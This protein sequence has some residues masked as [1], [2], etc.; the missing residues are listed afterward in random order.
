M[1]L[2]NMSNQLNV[3]E[4]KLQKAG[5]F[6]SYRSKGELKLQNC[7]LHRDKTPSLSINTIDKTYN[8][9]SCGDKGTINKLLSYFGID[10]YNAPKLDELEDLLLEQEEQQI[11]ENQY[12]ANE[13]ELIKF[14]YFHPYLVKRGLS[15]DFI[16]ANKIGFDPERAR[17]TIPI[18]F[19]DKYYG[20]A[21]RTVIDEIP[22]ITYNKGM[23]KDK[24]L[25]MPVVRHNSEF[26][27]VVEGPID[28]LKASYFG[29][30]SACIMGC[31]PSL[32][33]I[34]LIKRIANGRKIVLA[35]D[36]DDPGK[37][38]I[39]KWFKLTSDIET[40]IFAYSQGVKDIGDMNKQQ[41]ENGLQQS[42]LFWESIA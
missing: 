18:Y 8:C 14:R 34:N 23:P 42:A 38:G 37:R 31:N 32:V 40:S 1:L 41:F 35:L 13:T 16:L 11:E 20:C 15:K 22:K 10:S 27:V 19:E 4:S 9:F 33:Q 21:A 30:D 28:A 29:Q 12:T 36:N 26:L 7:P 25:Y 5:F 3:I 6:I 2:Q 17:V 24:I 39:E